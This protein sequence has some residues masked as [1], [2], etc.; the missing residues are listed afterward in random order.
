VGPEADT[1]KTANY[2][3]AV[4]DGQHLSAWYPDGDTSLVADIVEVD[5]PDGSKRN[6]V[7][8]G[9]PSTPEWEG[10]VV[11]RYPNGRPAISESWSGKGYVVVSGP[12]PEAPQGWRATAGADPDGL[13][14]DV[15]IDMIQAALNKQPLAAF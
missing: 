9:G 12:H 4:A 13:D 14:Y 10:G 8:W 11:A 15:A 7:W 6:L 1:D 3:F 2:G 5:F